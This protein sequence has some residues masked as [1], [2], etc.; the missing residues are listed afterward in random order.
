MNDSSEEQMRSCP[1]CGQQVP[2]NSSVCGYC[3]NDFSGNFR[4]AG[5]TPPYVGGSGGGFGWL[6]ALVIGIPAIGLVLTAAFVFFIGNEVDNVVD[7]AFDEA[8]KLDIPSIEVDA[9]GG[10]GKSTITGKGSY[11]TARALA[12]D[13]NAN[14]VKCGQFDLVTENDALQ[15]ATCF[16]DET[17]PLTIQVMYDQLSYDSIVDGYKKQKD[18]AVAYGTNWTVIA[19]TPAIAKGVATALDGKTN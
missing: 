14:G 11:K 2:L 15:A 13:L 5:A 9:G 19:P 7:S 8:G 4:G 10:D 1:T 18:L 12:A 16:V 6:R 17:T 3:G